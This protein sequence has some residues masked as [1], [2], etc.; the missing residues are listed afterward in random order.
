[1]LARDDDGL[2][3]GYARYHVDSTWN[4]RRPTATL[5]V[6]ELIAVDAAAT[7]RLWDYLTHVDWV[8]SVRADDRSVDDPIRWLLRDARAAEMHGR[9]DF[10]WL[11]V[12]DTPAI[13][14]GRRYLVSGSVVVE[15]VDQDGLAGGRFALDGSP[16]GARCTPT[17]AP[18]DLE[19]TVGALASAYLGGT[20]LRT[21]S[22]A[23]LVEEHRRGSLAI[24]DAMFRSPT[25]PWCSTWF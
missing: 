17:D 18:A 15:V 20:T 13:L 14:E 5:T 16:D 23:G 21:L 24:A 11:R 10:L 8:V 3:S 7:A 4:Q 19:L 12:L 2:P 6:D 1:V 22:A 25:T 9:A